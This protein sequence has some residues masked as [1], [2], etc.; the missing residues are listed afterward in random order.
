MIEDQHEEKLNPSCREFQA[1]LETYLEGEGGL[2]AH[3]G[4]CP[5]CGALFADL[6]LIR[7]AA[8]TWPL[9]SPAPRVWSNIRARLETEGFFREK[10]GFWKR[11]MA[12]FRLFPSAAPIGAL[13]FLIV[14]AIFL[15]SPGDLYHQSKS[16]SAPALV[17]TSVAP[18]TLTVVEANLVRTVQEMEKS[19]KT[20][21][22]YLDPAAKQTYARGLTSLDSSIRE[23]LASLQA[24]P[25]NTLARRYLM[26]AYSEKADVLA[27]A[28]E[29]DGR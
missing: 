26:Q 15:F 11:W 2:P 13:V 20:R 6:A 19:Y 17:A 27:S 28:L 18:A 24:Q 7:S 14:F 3:A 9:E 1:S 16:G 25:Q 29:Y 12:P 4:K 10:E 21:E 8:E 5:A 23:C 22:A